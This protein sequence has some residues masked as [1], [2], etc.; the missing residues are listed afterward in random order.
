MLQIQFSGN[1]HYLVLE[2]GQINGFHV[3]R[4]NSG[5]HRVAMPAGVFLMKHDYMG[6]IV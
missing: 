3:F 6:L 2:K 1:F 4:I 5:K